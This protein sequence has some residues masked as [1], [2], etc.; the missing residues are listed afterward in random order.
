MCREG[1]ISS[2]QHGHDWLVREV[3]LGHGAGCGAAIFH[4]I[5]QDGGVLKVGPKM[6]AIS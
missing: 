6:G 1:I 2:I 5:E 4:G 3:D